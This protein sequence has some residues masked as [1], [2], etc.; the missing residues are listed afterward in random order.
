MENIPSYVVW[1][2][3]L[4]ESAKL[5]VDGAAHRTKYIFL[6]REMSDFPGISK[7]LPNCYQDELGHGGQV[8]ALAAIEPLAR[9]HALLEIS[10]EQQLQRDAWA[11]ICST[12]LTGALYYFRI[13]KIELMVRPV[14]IE[15]VASHYKRALFGLVS[16]QWS[17]HMF[18]ANELN[19]SEQ[20]LAWWSHQCPSG[21]PR[22]MLR[23]PR[24][25]LYMLREGAGTRVAV[26]E[27]PAHFA[28]R[29]GWEA[30]REESLPD[31]QEAF[32]IAEPAINR[33]LLDKQQAD[34]DNIVEH[35]STFAPTTAAGRLA[36]RKVLQNAASAVNGCDPWDSA[37]REEL[38]QNLL[39]AAEAIQEAEDSH[40]TFSRLHLTGR[41]AHR[42]NVTALLQ[43]FFISG[44]LHSDSDLC[45]VIEWCCQVALPKDV[46]ECALAFIRG[47]EGSAFRVPSAATLSRT[48]FKVDVA[49]M[50]IFRKHLESLGEVKVFVQTDATAQAGRQYQI[51]IVN[52][53]KVS[54]LQMLHKDRL[55]S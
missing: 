49:W 19:L 39:S 23:L 35:A 9:H 44:F 7:Q 32:I 18:R 46:S 4:P 3:S 30:F 2:A 12:G 47:T 51:S 40:M 53:V 33:L 54:D 52:C 50:L 10:P 48:R 37:R 34:D 16:E 28:L 55:P 8:V 45:E 15:L 38:L 1:L 20:E 5:K 24:A 25:V 31:I 14:P 22:L 17:Q 29:A 11:A 42:Y 36:L 13:L 21:I 41:H 6:D 43:Y 26:P 27:F